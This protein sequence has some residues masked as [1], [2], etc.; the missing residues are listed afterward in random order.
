[1]F[2]T[3]A[4]FLIR[5]IKIYILRKYIFYR[6]ARLLIQYLL[7]FIVYKIKKVYIIKIL[8]YIYILIIIYCRYKFREI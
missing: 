8:F 6:C 7:I 4:I 3:I 5:S 2:L 1:M